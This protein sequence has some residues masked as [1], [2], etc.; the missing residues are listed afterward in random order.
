M[1]PLVLI[2]E[3]E[4]EIATILDAYLVREGFRTVRA[5]DGQV[6]M[7][8]HASLKPDLVLLDLKMPRRNGWAVLGEIR[9]RGDTPVIVITALDQDIDKLQ[10]LRMG[11]DDFIVKPFNAAEV[12]ARAQAV[13]RRASG[14]LATEVIRA[15]P[16]EIDTRQHVVRCHSGAGVARLDL[17]LT[18]FRILA[19]MARYPMRVFSRAEL[20]DACVLDQDILDRTV[21]SHVSK[22]RRKLASANAGDLLKSVWRVG[23]RLEIGS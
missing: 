2:V 7:D 16:L 8:L 17:T 12:G 10:A 14:V 5:A 9:R 3:D 21:D 1:T 18:E 19:H 4:A 20:I 15:G 11:A 13:L 23:Y 6:A 22:L